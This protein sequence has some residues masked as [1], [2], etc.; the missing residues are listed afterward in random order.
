V[1]DS[2]DDELMTQVR[3]GDPEPLAVLFERYQV[4]L[5]NFFLRQSGQASTSED[6][7]QEVFLRVL[8]YKHTFRGQGQFKSWLFQ[9]A[10]S[11]R[12]DHYRKRGRE[13][14]LTEEA[15]EMLASPH[16]GAIERIETEQRAALVR[17][18]LDRLPDAKRE[19]LVM[20]RFQNL[21]YHEI[22]RVLGCAEGTVKVRVH[23]AMKELREQF[24]QL[25]RERVA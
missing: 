1:S 4:P 2:T 13:T 18:A 7:V 24:L 5:Y 12:A 10:R 22:A 14:E 23:R 6:L 17:A 11:A 15:Q 19:V 8:K 21:R 25:T 16:P 20:S 9:I 3:D